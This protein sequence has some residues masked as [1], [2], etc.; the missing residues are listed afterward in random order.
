[1]NLNHLQYFRVLAKT[2]HY[3]QAANLLNITQPSLSHAISSLEKELNCYLFEKQGRNIKLTKYGKIL[4]D[5]IEKGL[6][7]VDLGI[8]QIEM[9][10]SPDHGWIH[11]AFIYTLGHSFVPHLIK[12]F[13]AQKQNQQIKFTLKQGNTTELLKGLEDEKYDVALCSYKENLPNIKFTPITTEELVVVVSKNHPLATRKEIDLKELKNEYFIYYGKDSGIRPFMDRL[14][15]ENGFSPNIL[16]EVEEDSAV[17]GLVDIN[18]GVAVVPEISM[19]DQFHV[20][21]LRIS[22]NTNKR[23]IYMATVKNRYLP[24][25]VYK[26]CQYIMNNT[27]VK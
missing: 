17:L 12:D 23:Y 18:Y 27:N 7:E 11:L 26:F 14:F 10:T 4:Y 6:H 3:T 20:K 1:M 13:H 22:N 16:F 2:E 21:K 24:P 8:R 9:L 19:I 25:A 5:Y 15:L